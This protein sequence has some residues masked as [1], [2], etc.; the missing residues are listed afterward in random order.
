MLR[1]KARIR[2]KQNQPSFVERFNLVFKCFG[3][4]IHIVGVLTAETVTM[5]LDIYS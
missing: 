4:L 3:Y 2:I 5:T 1:Q